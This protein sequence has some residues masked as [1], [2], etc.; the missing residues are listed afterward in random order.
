MDVSDL[1]Q[2]QTTELDKA[3][4]LIR[5]KQ[6]FAVVG[7]VDTTRIAERMEKKIENAGLRCR[8]YIANRSVALASLLI[9]TGI[10]QV[11]GAL[12][13]I[14]IG[15]HN[16]VTFNCDYEICKCLVDDQVVCIYKK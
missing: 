16:L 11:T 3:D 15:I 13:A 8:V 4:D 2:I 7:A 14:G 10:T 1:I 9:P 12:S 6:S 5:R